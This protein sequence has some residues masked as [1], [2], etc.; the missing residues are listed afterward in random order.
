MRIWLKSIPQYLIVLSLGLLLLAGIGLSYATA[1]QNTYLIDGLRLIEPGLW[2][3]DWFATQTTHY[4]DNFA[5]VLL[6]LSRLS[7]SRV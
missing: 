1:N 5:V 3:H 6:L 2:Q 4:H 7:S